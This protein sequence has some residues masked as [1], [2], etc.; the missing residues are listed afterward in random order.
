VSPAPNV[1][2]TLIVIPCKF[3][4]GLQISNVAIV[5]TC[6]FSSKFQSSMTIF[7]HKLLKREDRVL[8]NG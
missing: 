4:G 5:V 2:P 3:L 8:A 6:D 7:H 1:N